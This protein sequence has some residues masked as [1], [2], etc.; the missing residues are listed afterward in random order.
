MWTSGRFFEVLGVPATLGRTLRESDDRRGGGA[1]GPVVVISHRF[2]MRR[3]GGATDAVGRTLTLDRVPFT[4]VGVT[5][6]GFMGPEVG[7]TFDVAVP[8]GAEPLLRGSESWLGSRGSTWLSVMVR[9]KP[10]QT[11]EAAAAALA[12]VRPQIL[13][14]TIPA[15]MNAQYREEFRSKR[16]LLEPAAV[17]GSSLRRN[18]MRPLAALMAVVALVL[19]V[20]C[21][22]IAHLGLARASARR[23]E[24]SV[25]TAL[26]ASRLQLAR[27][28][29]V[30]SL[31]LSS[32]GAALGLLFASWWGDLL[33]RQFSTAEKTVALDIPLDWRVLCFTAALAVGAAVLFGTV[34]ALRAARVQPIEAL[35]QKGW[36]VPGGHRL[37]LH[38]GT[39][40]AQVAFSLVLVVAAGLFSRTFAA[41]AG[42]DLGFDRDR[43]LIVEL[44]AGPGRLAPAGRAALFERVR[45]SVAALPGVSSAATSVIAPLGGQAWIT[46]LPGDGS[47]PDGSRFA[48]VNMVG[49][50]WFATFGTRILAGREFDGRDVGG[51]PAVAI[52]NQAFA[53]R[54]L[55]GENPIG[56]T[57]RLMGSSV[58]IVGLATDAAYE[59]VRE[60]VPPTLYK[61]I[62]QSGNRPPGVV[63]SVRAVQGSPEALARSVAS[64]I[65]AV[66]PSLALTFRPLA[67]A[68]DAML[69]NERLLAMLSSFFGGLALLLAALGLFGVTSYGVSRHRTEIAIRIALG[70][71]PVRVLRLVLGRVAVTVGIGIVLGVAA[72]LAGTRVLRALLFGIEP[73]DPLTL[74]AAALTLAA[75]AALAAW[76]PARRAMRLDPAEVLREG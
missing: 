32:V 46:G 44:D 39:V 6:P 29:L 47:E 33:V 34:P 51:T 54:Y 64:A 35:N 50:D 61:P 9:L 23:H 8:L 70:A 68:V 56:R 24:L 71:L 76:L 20:A 11:L 49:P 57:L 75:V 48:F 26:G 55:R 7:R 13:D 15:G 74:L 41:L 69:V 25:R 19:L 40:V 63:L 65:G 67:D 66:D 10:G 21:A 36:D 73:G 12:T 52:V 59:S 1:D 3:F 31:L 30:E 18:S 4:I 62:G 28:L 37:F 43:V 53:R 5:P 22:N 17:G 42:R 16:F 72:S 14:A 58:E 27:Q 38:H 45:E 2:W 60:P